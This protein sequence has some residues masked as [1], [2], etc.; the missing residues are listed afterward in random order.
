MRVVQS[1]P[2]L[3]L[4]LKRFS[5]FG[6]KLTQPINFEEKLVLTSPIYEGGRIEYELYGVTLHYGSGPNN[7]HYISIVKNAR[8]EWCKMD[9][10]DVSIQPH[11][12]SDDKRNTYQLHYI[13][14]SGDRLAEAIGQSAKAK[15]ASPAKQGRPD[16]GRSYGATEHGSAF[17]EPGTSQS[18]ARRAEA[19]QAQ[20]VI[21]R[22]T[23]QA[24]EHRG[25]KRSREDALD[26]GVPVEVG[27]AQAKKARAG[28]AKFQPVQGADFYAG[29]PRPASPE[30]RDATDEED[31]WADEQATGS[32][33]GEADQTDGASEHGS[34]G[35]SF[36]PVAKNK[37]RSPQSHVRGTLGHASPGRK[38]KEIRR[39]RTK[40]KS[41]TASPYFASRKKEGKHRGHGVMKGKEH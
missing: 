25:M 32:N 16:L 20:A 19:E 26:E 33:G 37:G 5:P 27:T 1:P 17:D 36:E 30:D 3:S 6:K 9:D 23:M 40:H 35:G 8:K 2:V 22:K 11:L 39:Q 34:W 12:S 21:A 38:G 24:N 15:A 41:P 10:S 13:R 28:N 31:G 29:K 7:G 4:H 18:H 14:K